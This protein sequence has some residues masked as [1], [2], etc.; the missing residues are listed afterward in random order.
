MGENTPMTA[1]CTLA[2]VSHLQSPPYD[3]ADVPH[4][5]HVHS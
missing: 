5:R 2:T 4:P 3:P 1:A